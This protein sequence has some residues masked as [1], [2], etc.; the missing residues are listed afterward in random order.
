MKLVTQKGAFSWAMYDWGN[1]AFATTVMAGFYPIFF[2]DFWSKGT[3]ATV[4]TFWLGV[5]ISSASVVVAF[6]APMLGAMADHGGTKKRSLALFAG[7]GILATGCLFLVPEGSWH[8]S[9]FLYALASV[10]FLCS[11]VFYDSLL[12]SVS[13]QDTVDFVSARGYALGYLGGGLLFLLNVLMVEHP[14]FFGLQDVTQAVSISF[15]T[16]ALWWGVFTVPLLL[17]VK[18][19]PGGHRTTL[20]DGA[21]EGFRRLTRTFGEIKRLRVILLFL[22]AYWFYIDGVDTIVTMAVDYGKSIGF[23]TGELI[24]ALLLV[25]FIAFPFSFLLGYLGQRWG[26]KPLIL[27]CVVVYIFV[28]ILGSQLKLEPFHLFGFEISRFYGIAV[29]LATVQGGL[30]SLS[31][32]FYSRIIPRNKSAEFFGFYNMLGKFATIVGPV[33]MGSVS[34]ITGNPRAG[35]QSIALLFIVGGV[36][37]WRVNEAE[38]RRVA[39][40]ISGL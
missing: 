1:S 22:V 25:Q 9:A 40:E 31:R 5:T 24:T 21:R 14:A 30:Q 36:L 27:L 8:V 13:T 20:R 7:I 33:L 17:F 35:I 19:P 11:L 10:G 26:A 15:L 16:V 37:L 4:S 34:R 32:S 38:G 18:E 29:I 23:S 6:L 12:V 3:E 28:T 39:A 2:K